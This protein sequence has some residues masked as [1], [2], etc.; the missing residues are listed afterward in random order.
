[1]PLSVGVSNCAHCGASVGTLF[2]EGAAPPVVTKG[3]RRSVVGEHASYHE[4]IEKAQERANNS[5]ILALASFFCP[6][7]GF[8]MG[9]AAIVMSL[10]AA[11]TLKADNVEDGRGSATAGLI[12]G[13]LG[14]IAQ[15]G[16]VVYVIKSGKMP[17]VG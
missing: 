6:G 5:V 13:V 4:R 10:L 2:S 11:R 12:I 14:L 8:F 15:G 3:K 1:M 16:Y 17:F 9:V 7:V